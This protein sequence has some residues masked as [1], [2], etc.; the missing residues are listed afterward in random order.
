[1]LL[2]KFG[3]HRALFII[4]DLT[5]PLASRKVNI[6]ICS[7]NHIWP[8]YKY[9]IRHFPQ[10]FL[11]TSDP[12]FIWPCPIFQSYVDEQIYS[13]VTANKVIRLFSS[14]S[15]HTHTKQIIYTFFRNKLLILNF[16]LI[17]HQYV[18]YGWSIIVYT[19]TIS[20]LPPPP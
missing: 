18:P 19:R 7:L 16:S 6:I 10:W 12:I 14:C 5:W 13:P 9:H 20:A 1:M 3:S 15:V 4:F 2:T 8:V 11:G 17:S